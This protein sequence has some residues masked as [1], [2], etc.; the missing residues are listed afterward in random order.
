M[1]QKLS[2]NRGW[3]ALNSSI[4]LGIVSLLFYLSWWLTSGRLQSPLLLFLF[5]FA[6]LYCAVQLAGTWV[7]YLAANRFPRH[8]RQELEKPL[9]VDVFVTAYDEDAALVESCL[10][11]A[12]DMSGEHLTWLLD[13]AT[14][15]DLQLIAQRLGVGY[16]TREGNAQ[17][18]AG[19][20]NAA[21]VQTSGDIVAIF[22]VDHVPQVDF[23]DRTLG[24]FNDPQ[25]GFVQ[26]MLTFAYKNDTQTG[27]AASE[28]SLDFYNPASRGAD[29]LGA[30][31]L[32]GSNALIRRPA[33]DSIGGYQPGLAEDLATS[34]ALH[35]AGWSSVYVS[36]PLAPGLAPPDLAAWFE[37]QF[38]WSRGVF[39]LLV[40]KYFDYWPDLTRG[41][42]LGYAVRMTYYWIGLLV[43]VHLLATL[44]V[45]FLGSEKEVAGYSQYILHA[46][47]LALA[48]FVIRAV[49][50]RHHA[51]TAVKAY[52]KTPVYLQWK[53]L[54]LVAGTW[55]TYTVAWFLTLLR[56]PTAFRPTPK[57]ASGH[58]PKLPWILPQ[59][60][61]GVLILVGVI[62]RAN[63]A[64]AG[65]GWLVL[66]FAI[67][68]AASQ[69]WVPMLALKEAFGEEPPPAEGHAI[70]RN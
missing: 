20:L 48:T 68:L 49:A 5:L 43:A 41:Q 2:R 30:A 24:H 6:L 52:L 17:H 19:N 21:L 51:S 23:L 32:V 13:D 56:V 29:A 31:T 7:L 44:I 47:P 25:I 57:T 27:K 15:P 38:K 70:Q 50:L 66:A 69:F 58:S 28:S 63:S 65:P 18:K 67:A 45:L 61:A 60:I 34:I 35:A 26:V 16:L 39:E 37:Q 54:I 36:E 9:K 53:P 4:W 55:P 40:T 59:L 42:Q 3:I 1:F 64:D 10:R 22:D 12:R 46:L 33:L 14:R 8:R 62:T 11:A